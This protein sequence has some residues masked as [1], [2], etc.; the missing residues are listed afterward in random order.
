MVIS[1][2]DGERVEIQVFEREL[3][4]HAIEEGS[5]KGKNLLK[6]NLFV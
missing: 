2:E 5:I 6:A 3:Q 1:Q 4:C